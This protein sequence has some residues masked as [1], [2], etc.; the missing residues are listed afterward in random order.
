MASI[1]KSSPRAKKYTILYFDHNGKRRK[2]TGTADKV[3]TERIAREIENRVA[4]RREGIIDPKA[5]AYRDHEARPLA[6]HLDAYAAHLADKGRTRAHISLTVSR[7]RRVVALFR[8]APLAEIEAGNSATKELARAA[9]RLM[10]W[11]AKA[12]LSDLTVERVQ[13]ALATLRE[14]GRSLATCNH[15]ATAISGFAK[16]CHDTHRLR[17]HPLRG[18]ERFNAEEDRRHDRRTISLEELHRLIQ[19]AELGRRHNRMTG[20]MRA[21]CYRLAV[22][23]GLRFSEIGSITPGSFDWH[24][25]TV[26]VTAGYTKNGEAAT[27]PLPRDLAHDLAAYVASLPPGEPIF[28][29]PRRGRGA[30]MLRV[31]LAAAG[32]PYRD[33]AGLVFDF[34]SLRCETATLADQAGISPRVVQ[35]MMRHSTLELTGRYTR[36]RAVDIEAAASLLPSLKPSTP[37]T[38]TA[39]LTGTDS[40]PL[41]G[42]SSVL[43]ATENATDDLAPKRNRLTGKLLPIEGARTQNP[44]G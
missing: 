8:G 32:I 18:V 33:A 24:A 1:F 41:P 39:A 28:P 11:T 23:T 34:H 16:W 26:T 27:L 25:Q 22:A 5:E 19:A 17:E 12:R 30:E 15:H 3:V 37:G 43:P 38:E 6:E 36:P 2:K 31:D 20:P 7:A 42:P 4:L 40:R 35:R 14:K 10:A 29:F 21:I 13:A 9:D 44:V